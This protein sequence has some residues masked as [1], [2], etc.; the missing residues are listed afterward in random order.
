M[1]IRK[2]YLIEGAKKATGMTVVI[3]VFRAFSTACYLFEAGVNKIIPTD[4]IEHAYNLKEEFPDIILVGEREGVIIDQF[5]YNN[6]PSQIK[7]ENLTGKT[8]VMTTSAGTKGLLSAKNASQILTGSFVNAKA[9]TKYIKAQNPEILSI[10][11]LGSGGLIRNDEDDFFADYLEALLVKEDFDLDLV[12]HN[13]RFGS[14]KRFFDPEQ[15]H[16]PLDDF[17]LCLD[18]NRFDFIIRYENGSLNK[19]P[20]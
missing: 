16:S 10:V 12:K 17:E 2:L 13:L 18:F 3:D 19:I 4:D 9:I 5:D 1:E 6:S 7:G 14:G 11:A 15:A 20:L 8:V